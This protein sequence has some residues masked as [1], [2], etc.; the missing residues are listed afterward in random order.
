MRLVVAALVAMSWV[1]CAV[2]PERSFGT[3]NRVE[4][5]HFLGRGGVAFG[6]AVDPL[7]GH[8]FVLGQHVLYELDD[9][10]VV[11]RHWFDRAIP[12]LTD[13]AAIGDGRLALTGPGEGYRFDPS[14]G[15]LD[16][17]FCFL[18]DPEVQWPDGLDPG[19]GP[20]APVG[21]VQRSD[22]VAVDLARG[23]IYTQPVSVPAEGGG[24]PARSQIA[25][26]P[27]TGGVATRWYELPSARFRAGGM[28]VDARG[29]LVLGR[30]DELFRFDLDA[31]LLTPWLHLRHAGVHDIQGLAFD[32]DGE[33]LL[34]LDDGD[35]VELR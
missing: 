35:L 11:A 27:S 8:R 19:P 33:T 28:S 20:V 5:E 14:T 23:R 22:A 25:V 32:V 13:V 24:V 34:V 6:I 3:S 17:W 30:W 18:P 29:E 4:L 10:T 2:A 7:S 31:G 1:G 21:Y 15:A 12:E 9:A 16:R 26:F